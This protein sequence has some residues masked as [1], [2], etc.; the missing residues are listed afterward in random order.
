MNYKKYKRI[1]VHKEL[2][3]K[4]PLGTDYRKQ[5]LRQLTKNKMGEQV[6]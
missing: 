2:A 6:G 4:V 3:E 1:K 5:I